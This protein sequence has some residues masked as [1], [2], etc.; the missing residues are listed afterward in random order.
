MTSRT[1]LAV[2]AAAL[3]AL[4]LAGCAEDSGGT[5]G[6]T[7]G[8]AGGAPSTSA[9][10]AASTDGSASPSAGAGGSSSAAVPAGDVLVTFARQGGIAGVNDRLVIRGDGGY[11]LQT[12]GGTR[13]GKLT[14]EELAALKAA[15]ASVDINKVPSVNDG[16]TVA[17]GFT[18]SIIYNGREV[19]AEDGAIPPALQPVFGALSAIVS[20]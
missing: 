6:G 17:D 5:T 9:T 11:S 10:A 3:V 16:G 4:S 20:K 1:P 18:Y 15:L 2:A 13:T 19:V 8:S 7:T 12:R 14:A